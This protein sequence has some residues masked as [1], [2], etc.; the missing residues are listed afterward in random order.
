MARSAAHDLTDHDLRG[1]IAGELS[2]LIR[3]VSLSAEPEQHPHERPAVS[4][5]TRP[6]L[7]SFFRGNEISFGIFY[8]KQFVVAVFWSLETA[9][10]AA[11]ALRQAGFA[12]HDVI[13]APGSE[14]L[15]HVAELRAQTGLW[16]QLMR[17]MSRFFDTEANLI[18]QYVSWA[19]RGA[20][21]VAVYSREEED[22]TKATEILKP[23]APVAAHWYNASF[24]R[25]L[26]V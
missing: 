13:A 21:F 3:S 16:G 19:K 6:D 9:D 7:T 5:P 24:V 11:E 8:P 4:E 1:T 10:K 26:P 23:F 20:A 22:A 25:T 2:D 12:A 14:V 18:D 17:E 15:D